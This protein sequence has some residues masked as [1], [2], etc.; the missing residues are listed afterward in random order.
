[1]GPGSEPAFEQ[2]RAGEGLMSY[3]PDKMDMG[4]AKVKSTSKGTVAEYVVINGKL[5]MGPNHRIIK[6]GPAKDKG[7]QKQ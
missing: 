3:F 7:E 2:G 4:T 6:S 1:M 5:S